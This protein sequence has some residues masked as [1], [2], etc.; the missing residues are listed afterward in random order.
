MEF[1]SR[2]AS[3]V[4]IEGREANNAK[5]RTAAQQ[6]GLH[7]IEFV[8]DDVRN[9][10]SERFGLFDV[11]VCSGILYHLPGID[12]CR[13]VHAIAEACTRLTIIDLHLGLKPEVSIHYGTAKYNGVLFPEH[14]ECDSVEQ[15]TARVWASLDNPT[16][17]WFTRPSL[18]NLLRDTGYSSVFEI[19]RPMTFWDYSDR[20]TFA[21]IKGQFQ[22]STNWNGAA[23]MDI[24]EICSLPTARPSVQ[25]PL[26]RWK[27]IAGGIKRRITRS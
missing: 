18:L 27:L 17:F 5:A 19:L 8:T 23:E 11:V 26:P 2:G 16:S 21:A 1:A 25:K 20:F 14:G 15:K 10:C 24:P 9:F 13:F 6:K 22:E 7:N 3:V 12:A 4:A